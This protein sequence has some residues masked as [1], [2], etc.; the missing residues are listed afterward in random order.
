MAENLRSTR[1]RKQAD[2]E[3]VVCPGTGSVWM[4]CAWTA[5]KMASVFGV[6]TKSD[7]SVLGRAESEASK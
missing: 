2:S 3:S 6:A 1:D 4:V 5:E 7:C